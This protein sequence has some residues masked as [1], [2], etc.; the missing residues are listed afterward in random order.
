[1]G[2]EKVAP[3]IGSVLLLLAFYLTDFKLVSI[4]PKPAFSS[5]LVLTFI[6]MTDTWC[7][8]SYLKTKDK[9]EWLVVPAIVICAF[10]LDLL[11]AVFLGIAFS[12][13]IFVAAFFKSGVV[14]FASNGTIIQSTIER[15]F[16]SGAW[17]NQNGYFIQ[18]IVLQNYLF[19]G[20]ATS[21]Y[22]YIGHF[23]DTDPNDADAS[24]QVPKFVILDLTL[25]TGMDTSTVGIFTDIKNL[26]T[27]RKCKLFLAGMSHNLRAIL[28]VG[29][30]KPDGG[31][32]SKRQLRFFSSLDDALG[33]AEDMLLEMEFPGKDITIVGPRHRLNSGGDLGLRAALRHIDEQVSIIRL[34]GLIHT[35]HYLSDAFVCF[36]MEITFPLLCSDCKSIPQC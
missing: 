10:V 6:D 34:I 23:F 36:S 21:V 22:N 24:S 31:V 26:C 32:R 5:T 1:M 25:V 14:K 16:R 4:L 3:Q 17:L 33:K 2:A 20:N 8:K 11:S 35:Q 13:F 27:S 7:Y 29:G 9:V 15:P 30:V 19:F 12:T 28:A 18:A